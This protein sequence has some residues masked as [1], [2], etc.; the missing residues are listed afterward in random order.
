M[1]PAFATGKEW[2]FDGGYTVQQR[3][4]G[5][6]KDE[7]CGLEKVNLKEEKNG[8]ESRQLCEKIFFPEHILC[9]ARGIICSK[10]FFWH[11]F[12]ILSNKLN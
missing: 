12:C 5:K 3:Q 6:I 10:F 1:Q 4:N 11:G 8:S 2:V 7:R 9:C